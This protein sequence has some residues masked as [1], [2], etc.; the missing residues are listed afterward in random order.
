M[1][2]IAT[3]VTGWCLKFLEINDSRTTYNILQLLRLEQVNHIPINYAIETSFESYELFFCMFIQEIVR[4][5]LHVFLFVI[6][7]NSD[8]ISL[9]H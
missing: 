6:N 1:P 4:V 3:F 8:F 5:Q 9:L 2:V 7:C